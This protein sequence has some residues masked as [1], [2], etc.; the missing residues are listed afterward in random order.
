MFHQQ[1]KTWRIAVLIS[2]VAVHN[3]MDRIAAR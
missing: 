1:A 3:G 2:D